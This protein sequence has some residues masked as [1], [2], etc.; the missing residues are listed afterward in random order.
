MNNKKKNRNLNL[1][2]KVVKK[3]KENTSPT[4]KLNKSFNQHD[5]DYIEKMKQTW[6]PLGVDIKDEK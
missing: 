2:R 4:D 1:V 3:Y 6:K 5:K